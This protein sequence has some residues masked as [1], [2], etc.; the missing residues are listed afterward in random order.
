MFATSNAGKVKEVQSF[1]NLNHL[2][3]IPLTEMENYPFPEPVEDGNSFMENALKKARH[4]YN[5][6]QEPIIADDSGL[7]VPILNGEPGIFSARYSG[8]GA[9]DQKNN[10]LLLEKLKPFTYKDRKAYFKAVVIYKDANQEKTF[11]GK[12]WGTIISA[13]KGDKGFGYDSLFYL[14]ELQKTFAELE[15]LYKNKYSHRGKAIGR[16]KEFLIKSKM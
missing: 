7:V 13:P 12:C 16:L 5:L 1:I 3:L 9:S 8:K 6:I 2:R 11:K 14:E 15:P 4:Y 10:N